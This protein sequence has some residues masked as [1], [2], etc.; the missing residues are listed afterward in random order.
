MLTVDQRADHP[1]LCLAGEIDLSGRDDLVAAATRLIPTSSSLLM[2]DF[3]GVTFCDS[4]GIAALV[5]IYRR[6]EQAGCRVCLLNVNDSHVR[7]VL[8]IS[9][10]D[11]LVTVEDDPAPPS[12][13]LDPR[14]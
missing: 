8:S 10:I 13:D 3:S 5:T 14:S 11:R 9:G 6:A 7:W 2:L 12:P 4:S 1:R